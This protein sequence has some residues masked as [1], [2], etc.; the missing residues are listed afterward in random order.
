M[1]P[2]LVDEDYSGRCLYTDSDVSLGHV[3]NCLFSIA[4]TNIFVVGLNRHWWRYLMRDS[5][6]VMV[7]A[8]AAICC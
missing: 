4:F 7:Y 3:A 6:L 1:W 2:L 8:L 5:L